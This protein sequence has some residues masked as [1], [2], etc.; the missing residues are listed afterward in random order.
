MKSIEGKQTEDL[1][2]QVTRLFDVAVPQYQ[3]VDESIKQIIALPGVARAVMKSE[4]K[5][6]EVTYDVRK[7]VAADIQR[8]IASEE[9]AAPSSIWRRLRLAWLNNLDISRRDNAAHHPACCSKP[10]PGAGSKHV[11]HH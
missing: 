2:T 7:S 11:H 5:Q 10:P 3:A 9:M 8:V 1:M 4:R 6:L